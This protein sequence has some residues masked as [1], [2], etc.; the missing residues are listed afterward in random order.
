MDMKNDCE[1]AA[2]LKMFV[3]FLRGGQA[4]KQHDHHIQQRQLVGWKVLFLLI[5]ISTSTLVKTEFCLIPK[6]VALKLEKLDDNFYFFTLL[7]DYQF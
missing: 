1:I 7:R 5:T 2:S 6:C 3:M 4:S